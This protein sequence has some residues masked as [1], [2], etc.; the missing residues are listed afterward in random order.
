MLTEA[1]NLLHKRIDSPTDP[2]IIFG[3]HIANELRKY[4]PRTL[5]HV[6]HAINNIVFDADM[7][8]YIGTNNYGIPWTTTRIISETHTHQVQLQQRILIHLHL[9]HLQIISHRLQHQVLRAQTMKTKSPPKFEI[10]AHV[11]HTTQFTSNIKTSLL[12]KYIRLF[13][14]TLTFV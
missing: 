3:Q 8:K 13:S 5:A 11:F 7:G 9:L 12:I 14:F 10:R 2:Y 4:D 1:Y 6:K